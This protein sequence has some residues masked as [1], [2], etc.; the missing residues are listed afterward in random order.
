[1]KNVIFVTPDFSALPKD[2]KQIKIKKKHIH[3]QLD[4]KIT[5]EK[6]QVI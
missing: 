4:K 5:K 3:K 2:H 1:M 6:P